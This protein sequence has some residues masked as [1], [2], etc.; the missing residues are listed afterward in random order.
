[1]SAFS[2]LG[3]IRLDL[4]NVGLQLG[5]DLGDICGHG[6]FQAGNIRLQLSLHLSDFRFHLGDICGYGGFQT[7]NIG[8]GGH[9]L[10]KRYLGSCR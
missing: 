1:M 8:L 2:S 3:D 6:G 10:G 9:T 7:G 5:L 4:G